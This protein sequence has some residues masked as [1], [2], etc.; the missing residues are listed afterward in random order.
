MSPCENYV[1]QIN[2]R[3]ERRGYNFPAQMPKGH[4]KQR[5]DSAKVDKDHLCAD[6]DWCLSAQRRPEAPR[7]ARA[8]AWCVTSLM[9][10]TNLP[11]RFSALALTTMRHAQT[12]PSERAHRAATKMRPARLPLSRKWELG[13]R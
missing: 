4:R 8:Q 9:C 12:A 13:H 5:V 1:Y 11:P 6:I 7:A 3:G 10:D 2:L